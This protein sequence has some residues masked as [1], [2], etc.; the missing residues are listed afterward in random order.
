[1]ATLTRDFPDGYVV[2]YSLPSATHQHDGGIR[3]LHLR[4]NV[5]VFEFDQAPAGLEHRATTTRSLGLI[6][7][8]YDTNSGFG[9][10][11]NETQGERFMHPLEE[12]N[13]RG[14]EKVLCKLIFSIWHGEGYYNVKKA[15]AGTEE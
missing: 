7:R 3:I 13:Q 4:G 2:F 11:N 15:A 6:N 10:T 9:S 12:Q 14:D 5:G 1:M 8:P